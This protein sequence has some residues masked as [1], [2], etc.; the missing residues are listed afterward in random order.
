M[1]RSL[2]GQQS[3]KAEVFDVGN[4]TQMG[5]CTIKGRSDAVKVYGMCINLTDGSVLTRP[6][7]LVYSR[8]EW[9]SRPC[10]IERPREKWYSEDSRRTKAE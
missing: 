7:K 9:A 6:R 1:T 5:H 10:P 8:L 2:G 3:L 4:G